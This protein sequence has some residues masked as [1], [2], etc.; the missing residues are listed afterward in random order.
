MFGFFPKLEEGELLFSALA[1]FAAMVGGK[2]SAAHTRR[3]LGVP[4]A[5]PFLPYRLLRTFTLIPGSVPSDAARA[6]AHNTLFPYNLAFAPTA[7]RDRVR[8]WMLFGFGDAPTFIGAGSYLFPSERVLRFC[9]ACFAEHG[10]DGEQGRWLRIHQCAGV[11]VCPTHLEPL[12]AG[13]PVSFAARHLTVLSRDLVGSA[14][15]PSIPRSERRALAW[16]ATQSERLLSVDRVLESRDLRA[17]LRETLSDFRWS[18]APSLVHSERLVGAMQ[19]HYVVKAVAAYN[20]IDWS[21][22]RLAVA[23]NRLLYR[24]DI[25]AHPLLVLL[26]LA[27]AGGS[28]DSLFV[29][30]GTSSLPDKP[31]QLDA[32]SSGRRLMHNLP[33]RNPACAQ[34]AGFETSISA[35]AVVG[36]RLLASCSECGFVYT[37]RSN[38]PDVTS[39]CS[40]CGSWDE[41][42]LKLLRSGV[43]GRAVCREICRLGSLI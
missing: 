43:S 19:K 37:W 17:A 40:T 42:L 16:L 8:N 32:I 30:G 9:P 29:N 1:R 36:G 13:P 6:I 34:F 20:G 15:A 4:R 39:V 3:A 11:A 28:V 27:T 18:R 41:L 31:A 38:Q 25:A 5:D 33:C 26:V 14:P 22:A 7:V 23:L 21:P 2:N 35:C 12:R 10:A 24:E